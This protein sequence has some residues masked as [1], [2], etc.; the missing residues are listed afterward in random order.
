MMG[1]SFGTKHASIRASAGE[2]IVG[3]H[4]NCGRTDGFS[5]LYR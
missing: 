4:S 5:A 1:A 2:K 3:R